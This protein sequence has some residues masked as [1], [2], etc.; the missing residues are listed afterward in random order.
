MFARKNMSNYVSE[1]WQHVDDLM[2]VVLKGCEC[3][4]WCN[5][6]A[7]N[8]PQNRTASKPWYILNF[9][10]P[11]NARAGQ[12]TVRLLAAMTNVSSGPPAGGCSGCLFRWPPWLPRGESAVANRG[13]LPF[14]VV[15]CCTW[16]AF[17]P[18]NWIN[19]MWQNVTTWAIFFKDTVLQIFQKG[20]LTL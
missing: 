3:L 6:K 1:T 20:A 16:P 4:S 2:M 13:L 15:V 18:R 11:A 12:H 8:S 19:S 9:C 17:D 10:M 14:L 5:L 7:C